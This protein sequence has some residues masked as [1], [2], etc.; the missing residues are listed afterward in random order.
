MNPTILT[1]AARHVQA[2]LGHIRPAGLLVLG[3]GWN[4]AL[5][6][7]KPDALISYADIPG[8]GHPHTEGHAGLLL[9]VTVE[10]I[11]LLVFEGRRHL[12]EGAGWEPVAIPIYIGKTL[13]VS[14]ALLTNAA[15]GI[16]ADL[17][18]GDLLVIDDHINLMGGNPL[19]GPADHDWGPRFPDQTEVYDRRLRGLFDAAAKKDSLPVKHGTYLAVSGPAYETPAEI[20]AFRTMGADAVGMSTV[21]E[22]MLAHAAGLSVAA[23]SCITNKAAATGQPPLAHEDVLRETR[24]RQPEMARLLI[25]WLQLQAQSPSGPGSRHA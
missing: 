14:F 1:N 20:A 6:A 4:A 2:K 12:Y 25:S 13:G 22:A 24:R 10:N 23:I 18:P 3:S 15:G 7:Y 16:R 21:P 11:P 9:S 8:M 17:Q 5:S 19:I